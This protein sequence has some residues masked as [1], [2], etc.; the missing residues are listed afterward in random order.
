MMRKI[1]VFF[2]AA[3]LVL[4][5]VTAM[6]DSI[7]GRV[8]VT[9]KLGFIVPSDS[10]SVATG[11]I[12]TNASLIGGGGFIYGVT[13]SIAAEFDITHA[14]FNSFDTTNISFGAQYRYLGLPIRQ[15]VPY[16]GAGLDI[17]L[18]GVDGGRVDD[19]VGIHL[20]GGADYFLQKQLAV[21]LEAKGVIAGD[22][23]IHFA[24]GDRG[25][26]DPTGVSVTFGVRYFFN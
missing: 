15:L 23:D 14:G 10:S 21:T 9:G 16:G 22:A 8:G 4:T 13:D 3:A 5:A 26:Y 24:N 20:C 17:L 11:V 18:N 1:V 7:M 25:S 6:A 12:G 19:V 2:V